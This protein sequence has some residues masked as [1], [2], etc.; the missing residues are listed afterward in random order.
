MNPTRIYLCIKHKILVMNTG[1][2]LRS[3]RQKC[4]ESNFQIKIH[5]S[6]FPFKKS[7]ISSI[8]F[9]VRTA[10]TPRPRRHVN[11][12]VDDAGRMHENISLVH[13]NVRVQSCKPF[14]HRSQC[15]SDQIH[16][17]ERLY[18]RYLRLNDSHCVMCTFSRVSYPQD[19][20]QRYGCS[21]DI[22]TF[23]VFIYHSHTYR[24]PPP[25]YAINGFKAMLN[26]MCEPSR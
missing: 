21:S 8:R 4:C 2:T 9:A 19:L 5:S 6:F 17:G 1:F 13:V 20:E 16:L 18:L 3:E 12:R 22:S 15:I 23:T 14:P 26:D 11:T 24:V 10:A 7:H 25:A